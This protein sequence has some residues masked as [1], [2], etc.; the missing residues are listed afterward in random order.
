MMDVFISCSSKDQEIADAIVNFLETD[1]IQCWIA[2]RD[3]EVGSAYAASITTAIKN[4][5]IFLL[6]YSESANLSKHVLREVDIAC[7]YEKFIIPFILDNSKMNDAIEYY[8]SSTHWLDA[9][10]FP[11]EVHLKDLTT[12]VS[13]HLD[14]EKEKPMIPI[15]TAQMVIS[16]TNS[17]FIVL[18]GKSLTDDDIEGFIKLGVDIFG[19]EYAIPKYRYYE[20]RDVNPDI[21]F[22]VKHNGKIIGATNISP[23]TDECYEDIKSDKLHDAYSNITSEMILPYDMPSPYSV[24]FN[25]I[26]IDKEYQ[27]TG[28]FTLLYN[29]ALEKF[30]EL[31]ERDIYMKRMIAGAVSDKGNKLCKSFGMDKI[32]A[33]KKEY[34]V[35]YEVSMMPPKFH[36]KSSMAKKLFDLYS[37]KYDSEP[38]LFD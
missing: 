24:Y 1:K 37:K 6:V 10:S 22:A 16:Q 28:V 17:E 5:S 32:K 27:D 15:P 21:F 29:A 33:L 19:D 18:K 20:W 4:S 14:H 25:S 38:Y 36:V 12:L 9:I 7:K 13:K 3:D 23:V 30:I 31:T 2:H 26:A 34:Q 35:M 11:L 8:L